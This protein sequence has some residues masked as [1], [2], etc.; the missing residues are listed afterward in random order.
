MTSPTFDRIAASA[1]TAANASR[2]ARQRAAAGDTAVPT[3]KRTTCPT[4]AAGSGVDCARPIASWRRGQ[5]HA[6]RQRLGA[7]LDALAAAGK[8]LDL[9]PFN[10]PSPDSL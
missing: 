6:D 9:N 8:T 7:Q 5:P 2:G 10:Q 4:C 1:A 3:W